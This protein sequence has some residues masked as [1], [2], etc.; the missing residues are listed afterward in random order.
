MWRKVRA[1]NPMAKEIECRNGSD[2]T[3]NAMS[4]GERRLVKIGSPTQPSPRLVIVMPSCVALRKEFR[5]PTICRATF[6]RRCPLI[7]SGWSCV[8]RMR[9]KANSA[10][11]KNPFNRTSPSTSR[12]LRTRSRIIV[13]PEQCPVRVED[14]KPACPRAS[15]HIK[16]QAHFSKNYLQH[17]LQPDHSDGLPVPAQHDPQSLAA[18]LH[19]AQGNFQPQIFLQIKRGFHVIQDRSIWIHFRLK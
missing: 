8:S 13:S 14:V 12:I 9:T 19:P 5:F 16:S 1:E 6:A 7:A 15:N 3:C 18:A 11:T 10:A 4:K 17:I 2:W